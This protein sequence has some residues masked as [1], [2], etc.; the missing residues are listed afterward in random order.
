MDHSIFCGRKAELGHLQSA[1]QRMT[2]DQDYAS[3]VHVL[4]AESGLGKTRIVQEFYNWLSV[5]ADQ[6]GETGYWPDALGKE[7]RS[8]QVNP[9]P[10]TCRPANPLTYIWLGLRCPD[11]GLH[12]SVRANEVLTAEMASFQQ[13][14][15]VMQKQSLQR[16]SLMGK[17][18]DSAIEI[19]ASLA[20]AAGTIGVPIGA[21]KLG[22]DLYKITSRDSED[23]EPDTAEKAIAA[24]R[25][26]FDATRAARI[27]LII[28]LDDIQFSSGE[29]QLSKFVRQLVADAGEH[30]WPLLIIAT[31]WHREWHE[32]KSGPP[33]VTILKDAR[34]LRHIHAEN[35]QVRSIGPLRGIGEDGE[36]VNLAPLIKAKFPGLLPEQIESLLQKVDG[37]PR[38]LEEILLFLAAKTGLFEAFDQMLPLEMGA[39]ERLGRMQL[40]DVVGERLQIAGPE[41]YAPLALASL[42]GMRFSKQLVYDLFERLPEKADVQITDTGFSRAETPFGFLGDSNPVF[43]EF[44]QRIH[45]QVA[46]DLLEN[47]ARPIES[48]R[49]TLKTLVQENVRQP[50][51]RTT[52]EKLYVCG[53]ALNLFPEP[54]EPETAATVMVAWHTIGAAAEERFAYSEA[55][56]TFD[57]AIAFGERYVERLGDATPHAFLNSLA[58]AHMNKGNVLQGLQRLVEAVVSYDAAIEIMSELRARLGDATPPAFLNDL[59]AAY[60]N[61]GNVLQGLQRLEEAVVSYDAAIEIMS[62]LRARLG[63]ATPPAFLNDLA[64]AH[65]NKGVSLD[66]LQRLEEAVVSYDA[67]IEIRSEL[68]ARL[69]DATP[70]AFLNDLAAAYVNK[71]NVLQGLQRLEEAVVSYDAAIEIRSELRARL[72][73]ATPPAFLNDLAAA[74][75]NKGNVLQGLQRLEEAQTERARACGIWQKL[76]EIYPQNLEY[77]SRFKQ[78]CGQ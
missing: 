73:D 69:G 9:P 30:R 61:K 29:Y 75:M 12:N 24:V 11:T 1:W 16:R 71:G 7:G 78:F 17:V 64:G 63:D 42:Q 70:P 52:D 53:L 45:Q 32:E 38:Y 77:K 48:V 34:T 14:L 8:L 37:N 50:G 54:A 56:T 28:F 2:D 35:L 51:D 59:A 68:R 13:H 19:A 6:S 55:I 40:E 41:I 72:G 4:V 49:D 25:A 67:A 58:G 60:V 76:V 44:T 15:L 5:T 27:P 22:Y 33:L 10:G 47:I 23:L 26:F 46:Q 57:Q 39:L 20:G 43:G 66:S 36:E 18:K 62:E 21:L 74:H 65:M 3:E 31:S